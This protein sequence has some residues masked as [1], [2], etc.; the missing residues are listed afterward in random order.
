MYVFLVSYLRECSKLNSYLTYI[1]CSYEYKQEK[2][3]AR[4][5]PGLSSDTRIL[6]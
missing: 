2:K 5:F 4:K 6:I 1:R 3:S